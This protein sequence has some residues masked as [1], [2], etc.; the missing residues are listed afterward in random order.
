MIRLYPYIFVLLALTTVG[1]WLSIKWWAPNLT[2]TFMEQCAFFVILIYPTFKLKHFAILKQNR[3]YFLYNIYVYFTIALSLYAIVNYSTIGKRSDFA[4]LMAS[5]MA[6]LTCFCTYTLSI[7]KWMQKASRP[8]F[9]YLP[10]IAILYLPFSRDGMYGDLL[11]FICTP[12][13]LLLLFFKDLPKKQQMIWLLI[14]ILIVITGFVGDAR[15]HVIKFSVAFLIGMTYVFD[16]LYQ[17]LKH[18][19]WVFVIA[20]FILLFLG[21]SGTF[22]VFEMNQYIKNKSVSEET[23]TDTRTI[24]YTEVLSSAVNNNYVM[25]GR[26]I[27]RGYV[28]AFQ[29]KRSS[30]NRNAT[31][32]GSSERNSEVG[33]HNIFTWGGIVYVIIYSLMWCS[34]LYYGVYKS[35]NRYVRVVGF[36]LAFY[37]LYSW[38]E[39]FQS[40]SIIFISSWLMVSLCLSPYFRRMNNLEFKKYI[41]TILK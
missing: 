1:Q 26:G 17:K 18:I 11:G 30:D 13:I 41:A 21:L 7:P 22:N 9:K 38:V 35:N 10:L 28:S 5:N 20:P 32:L 31:T 4:G 25:W 34:V 6:M 37:Y 40:F 24:V 23:I 36:Y 8:L 33:M 29:E 15:S 19:V 14:A 12:A 3:A 2:V 39:N 16:K 27:G